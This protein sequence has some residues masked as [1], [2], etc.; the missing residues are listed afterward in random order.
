[1]WKNNDKYLQSFLVSLSTVKGSHRDGRIKKEVVNY[2]TRSLRWVKYNTEIVL[3]NPGNFPAPQASVGRC[4]WGDV[5]G[6]AGLKVTSLLSDKT[7]P[8]A[9][10]TPKSSVSFWCWGLGK[11]LVPHEQP[12]LAL[13][14]SAPGIQLPRD[15]K[16]PAQTIGSP[17]RTVETHRAKLN[18]P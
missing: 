1:M 5:V 17:R 9:A 11:A 12:R 10:N 4:G 3:N 6:V 15:L 18:H 16:T 2:Q 13:A 8:Q 7:P 14:Q